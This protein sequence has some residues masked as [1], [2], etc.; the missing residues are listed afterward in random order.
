MSEQPTDVTQRSALPPGAMQRPAPPVDARY[1]AGQLA[2]R[3]HQVWD[4]AAPAPSA[5]IAVTR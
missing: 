1:R 2:E 3:H 5:Y 4:S